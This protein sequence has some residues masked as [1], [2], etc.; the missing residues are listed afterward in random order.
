[1]GFQSV[2]VW[3]SGTGTD[4]AN[5]N[6][7]GDGTFVSEPTAS[8]LAVGGVTVFTVFTSS[9][10]VIT[11][12]GSSTTVFGATPA[13]VNL[14]GKGNGTDTAYLY[15]GA[16]SNS[17][18][19]QGSAARLSRAVN[20]VNVSDTGIVVGEQV[21]GTDDTV[22]ATAVDVAMQLYGNWA[23]QDA[24]AAAIARH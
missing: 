23:S 10:D 16:G 4:V 19:V 14:V 24:T 15:D 3:E 8:T 1:M 9:E 2:T 18:V 7:P 5:L 13:Q 21:L 22:S 11:A 20:G 12:L 17:L 6:S